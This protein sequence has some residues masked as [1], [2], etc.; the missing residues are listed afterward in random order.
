MTGSALGE[1]EVR[2]ESADLLAHLIR[3][4]C[5]N[6]GT[7]E[8]GFESRSA[9]VLAQYL[10]SAGLDV[11]RF[12]ALD[13]R[14]SLVARIEGTD[15]TAPTLLL[16]GHTD[17]VP[18]NPDGWRRDPFGGEII[19][20]EVWGRGAIDML[21]LTA[22]MAVATRSLARSGFRPKGSLVYLAVADEESLGTYGAEYLLRHERDA[23]RADYVVT[24]SG[25]FQMPHSQGPRLPVIVGEKGS[26]WC[27]ITVR[28]TP[29]HASQPFRT[30]NALVTAAEIVRRIADYRPPTL[31][32]ETWRRFVEGMEFGDWGPRLLDPERVDAVCD[33]L[34]VGM[35]R[36]AHACTHTTFAPTVIS[37]GTKTNVIPDHVELE[38]D[39]RS[40]PGQTAREL[41][42]MLADALGELAAHV[43]ISPFEDNP[44]TV[45]PADTPLWD[46]MERVAGRLVPG[47]ALVPYFSVGA[48]DARF[49]RRDGAVAYGF[50][51]FSRR[52]GFEEFGSMFHG[53]DE[54]VDIDS[55]VLSTRLFEGLAA[56]LL[57]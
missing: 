33:E 9:D 50:G 46:A 15:P 34:P 7:P 21:N 24:E 49:F 17:V 45:S 40:L 22:T 28:G 3:N 56:E 26:Y 31:V 11:E 13:G 25:G 14:D 39:V 32:H 19:D 48:T 47:S 2:A 53:N 6:D 55:L 20:D 4:A 18:A 52:I 35:A 44:S 12:A 1:A 23:V 54:R 43:E 42:R 10:G 36:Q 27:R 16:M 8:S 37:G 57:G 38:V 30:D 29:G 41:E 51:L 5:V